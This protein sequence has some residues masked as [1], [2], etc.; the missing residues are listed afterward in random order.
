LCTIYERVIL[1]W[2]VANVLI[3]LFSN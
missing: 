2:V 3:G 1:Y